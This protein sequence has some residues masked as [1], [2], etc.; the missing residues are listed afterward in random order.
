MQRGVGN[1]AIAVECKKRED[2]RV[3]DIP[4]PGLDERAALYRIPCEA[5]IVRRQALKELVKRLGVSLRK[6][7]EHDSARVSKSRLLRVMMW[8]IDLHG[9]RVQSALCSSSAAL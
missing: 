2:L 9:D 8:H 1:D 3:V 5:A 7:T 4:S 6:W